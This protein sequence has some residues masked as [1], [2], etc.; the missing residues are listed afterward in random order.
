MFELGRLEVR[1]RSQ[2]P[3]SPPPSGTISVTTA[4]P[5]DGLPS[6]GCTSTYPGVSCKQTYATK[7]GVVEWELNSQ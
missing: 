7:D 5:W 1:S 6:Y 2:Q 4:Y 3:S